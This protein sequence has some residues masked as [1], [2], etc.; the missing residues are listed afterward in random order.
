MF[1]AIA[2]A[3]AVAVT[4]AGPWLMTNTV[5]RSMGLVG[6]MFVTRNP[7]RSHREQFVV[8]MFADD[9][10]RG[11]GTLVIHEVGRNGRPTGKNVER[12]FTHA[13]DDRTPPSMAA[14]V[15]CRQA[16][17]TVQPTH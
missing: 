11:K 13:P 16:L 15:L 5:S 2:L 12:V 9:C 6:G 4:P 8:T 14:K 7:A 1:A 3:A 10:K 17:R